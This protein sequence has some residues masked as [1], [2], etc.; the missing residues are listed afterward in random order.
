[1]RMNDKAQ[2]LLR[3]HTMKTFTIDAQLNTPLLKII[4]EG[5]IEINQAVIYKIFTNTAR[6]IPLASLPDLTGYECFVNHVHIEDFLGDGRF[7][8][9]ELLQK[10]ILFALATR[11]ALRTLKKS[12]EFCLIIALNKSGCSFRFHTVRENESWLANDLNS[13]SQEAILVIE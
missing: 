1:M 2:R 9:K 4:Q 12:R 6:S 13:Y 11:K 5:F 7:T 3:S 8:Q 10:G